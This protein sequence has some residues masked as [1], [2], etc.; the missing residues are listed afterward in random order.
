MNLS[1]LEM[2]RQAFHIGL[3][4]LVVGLLHYKLI[5]ATTLFIIL[6]IGFIFSMLTKKYNIPVISWFLKMFDREKSNFPGEGAFFMVAGMF[7]VYG[8]FPRN[9]ALAAIMVLTL[10]DSVAHLLGKGLGKRKFHKNTTKTWL[11]MVG[12]LIAGTLGAW[13]FV[14]FSLAFIGSLLA[15]LLEAIE[16]KYMGYTLDDNIFVPVVAAIAMHLWVTL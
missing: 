11:G 10:G 3:G 5:N 6:T 2:R 13:V 14:P 12:G 9:I 4:I 7:L 8:V 15:M 16:L 1:R